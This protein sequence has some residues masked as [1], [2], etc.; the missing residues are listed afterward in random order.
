MRTKNNK[1]SPIVLFAYNCLDRTRQTA[2][3][4]QKNELVNQSE[5]FIK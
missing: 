3:V 1:L 2:E 5:L 4:S